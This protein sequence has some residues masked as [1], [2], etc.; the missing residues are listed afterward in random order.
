MALTADEERV[1]LVMREM[2]A[3]D[4]GAVEL[5]DPAELRAKAGPRV[6]SRLDIKIVLAFAAAAILVVALIASGP[7][8]P[9]SNG[10][11]QTTGSKVKTILPRGWKS[12]TYRQAR[13]SV[14]GG[15]A[16]LR[17]G[18]CPDRSEPTG[19]LILGGTASSIL[20]RN[21]ANSEC[22]ILYATDDYVAISP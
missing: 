18:G 17:P 12:Y 16:V 11:N 5:G 14:P 3:I 2:M 1:G 9:G 10:L 22:P 19:L 15:W 8:R 6:L 20:S 4:P 21:D 7:L 13:I